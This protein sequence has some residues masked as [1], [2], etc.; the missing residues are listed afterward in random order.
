M[1]QKKE[2]NRHAGDGLLVADVHQKSSESGLTEI[3]SVDCVGVQQELCIAQER[4]QR[5]NSFEKVRQE[6][7]K[8]T[9]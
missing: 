4:V 9:K 8:T 3:T 1:S 7:L 5:E 6:T 2:E